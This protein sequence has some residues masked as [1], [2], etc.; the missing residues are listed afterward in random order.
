MKKIF[1]AVVLISQAF[2]AVA[3]KNDSTEVFAF[4]VTDYMQN[5]ND[6]A[7]IVQI[8]LPDGF[9]F[10]EKQLGIIKRNFTNNKTDTAMIGFGR[11]QLIKGDYYYFGIKLS[12]TKVKPMANDLLYTKINYATNYKG[13]VYNLTRN[14]VYFSSIYDSV[15]YKFSSALWLDEKSEEEIINAF[16]NDIKFTGKAMEEQM[17]DQN[18][19][20]EGG[21]FNGIKLFTGMKTC[22]ASDVKKFLEYVIVRPSKYAGNTWRISETFATWMDSGTPTVIK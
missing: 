9:T 22:T 19:R 16:V 13:L 4:K 3:Q 14:A 1:F 12:N 21:I 2:F 8:L 10:K 5:I 15:F 7:T 11:C 6:S 20:I 18:K 17:P